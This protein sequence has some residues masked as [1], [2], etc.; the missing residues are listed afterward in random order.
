ALKADSPQ[1]FLDFGDRVRGLIGRVVTTL[2]DLRQQKCRIAGYGAAAK[3]CTLM[4]VAGI[5]GTLLD[6]LVDLNPV[7][8]GRFMRGNHLPIRP[9]AVL[10]KESA[11]DLLLVF[12]WNFAEEIIAQQ[13]RYAEL[14]GRFIVP[15]QEVRII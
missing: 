15:V 6:Y 14:G 4:S 5:D 13:H 10:Y 1:F 11:P 9:P 2:R 8:Q 12:E 7:K 3:A